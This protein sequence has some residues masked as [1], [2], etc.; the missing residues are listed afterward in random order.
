MFK[1]QIIGEWTPQY[2]KVTIQIC[3]TQEQFRQTSEQTSDSTQ[4]EPKQIQNLM[5]YRFV[6][7]ISVVNMNEASSSGSVLFEIEMACHLIK[8]LVVVGVHCII[9]DLDFSGKGSGFLT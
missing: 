1:F 7:Q 5:R 4:L 2:I 9:I 8:S 3:I 6:C